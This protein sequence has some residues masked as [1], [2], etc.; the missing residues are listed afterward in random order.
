MYR[1]T[2]CASI[3][4]LGEDTLFYFAGRGIDRLTAERILTRGKLERPCAEFGNEKL[5]EK[6]R[7]EI[8]EVLEDG[9]EAER[10]P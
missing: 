9:A 5:E 2:T 4:E 8:E 10:D 7:Q 3:G 6:A 1:E